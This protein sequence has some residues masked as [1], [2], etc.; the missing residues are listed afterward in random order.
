MAHHVAPDSVVAAVDRV[1]AS[2]KTASP[3]ARARER[4]REVSGGS[5]AAGLGG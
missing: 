3:D 2:E 5:R 4:I 1:T